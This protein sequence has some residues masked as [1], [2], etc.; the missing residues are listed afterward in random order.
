LYDFL[1]TNFSLRVSQ[2]KSSYMPQDS[3]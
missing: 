3:K 2:C 1:T